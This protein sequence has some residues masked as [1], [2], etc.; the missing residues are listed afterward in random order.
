MDDLKQA[1]K[2]FVATSNSGKYSDFDTLLSKFPELSGFD[3]TALK[4]F[5]ATSNSG[6]YKSEDVL[7]SKF[8]EFGFGKK[9]E[10]SASPSAQE[11]TSSATQGM[12]SPE[13]LVYFQDLLMRGN[14][15]I[16]Q[17]KS[18]EYKKI[19]EE[20]EVLAQS[21]PESLG[22]EEAKSEY[23][24]LNDRYSNIFKV[25]EPLRLESF[26]PNAAEISKK[27]GSDVNYTP[28]ELKAKNFVN[29]VRLGTI[30]D[31]NERLQKDEEII[32]EE[33]AEEDLGSKALKLYDKLVKSPLY[34]QYS[35]TTFT[36]RGPTKKE[37]YIEKAA[38]QIA[39][40]W[41][42]PTPPTEED[43][44]NLGKE[45]RRKELNKYSEEKAIEEVV[46]NSDDENYFE[47][48]YNNYKSISDPASAVI[49]E[50]ES[51]NEKTVIKNALQSAELK[52]KEHIEDFSTKQELVERALNEFNSLREEYGEDITKYTKDQ[53]ISLEAAQNKAKD[54][55]DDLEQNYSKIE[56]DA[57]SIGSA[58]EELD[59]FKRNYGALSKFMGE[60]SAGATDLAAGFAGI[61]EMALDF[62]TISDTERDTILGKSANFLGEISE[63]IRG[64]VSTPK[65]ID[66]INSVGEFMEFAGSLFASQAPQLLMNAGTGLIGGR[67]LMPLSAAGN[68][69]MTTFKDEEEYK[70][71]QR[72]VSALGVGVA[73]FGSEYLTGR[74]LQR[75]F[76][77]IRIARA[78]ERGASKEELDFLKRQF[79]SG[80]EKGIRAATKFAKKTSVNFNEEGLSEVLA[81]AGGNFVDRHVLGKKDV[82]IL[83]GVS[84]AYLT[85]GILGSGLTAAPALFSGVVSAVTKDPNKIIVKNLKKIEKLISAH[86]NAS[87]NA[88]KRSINQ[89]IGQ[90]K[91][92]NNAIIV[93][94]LERLN[95]M[96]PKEIRRAV[97]INEAIGNIREEFS[98]ADKD[99]NLS[100][101]EKDEVKSFLAQRYNQLVTEKTQL[102]EKAD[103]VQEQTTSEV[104]VQSEAKPGEE[105]AEG[106]PKT[107]SEVA[108]EEGKEEDLTFEEATEEDLVSDEVID[109]KG[110]TVG[111]VVGVVKDDSGKVTA[112]QIENDKTGEVTINKI[113]EQITEQGTQAPIE[114]TKLRDNIKKAVAKV[115]TKT[116]S[117]SFKNGEEMAAYAKK[118]YGQDI[119]QD[120]GARV[121]IKKDGSVEILVNEEL[122]DDTSF[123]HEVW[124]PIL[125]KAFGDDQNNFRKFRKAINNTLRDNG[126]T[127]LADQ[128]DDFANQYNEKAEEVPSEEYMAQLGGILTAAKIDVNNLTEADKTLLQQIKDIVNNIMVELTGQPVF[129]E[130]AKPKDILNF[131]ST[132]SD[133]MA[134]GE[135]VSGFFKEAP[136]VNIENTSDVFTSRPQKMGNFEIKYFEDEAEFKKLVD[137]GLV[138]QNSELDNISGQ[139][140]AIHQPDNLLVGDVYYNDKK[141]MDANG[142]VYYVLKFGNVW[143]SGKKNSATS[144]ANLINKSRKESTDGKGRLVLVRGSQ[145]KMI[146]S[147]QGVK[148]AMEILESLMTDNLISKSDFRKALNIVGKK[149]KVNFSGSDSAQSIKNDI[150][151]KFMNVEDSTFAKRGDFF[152]DLVSEIGKLPSAKEN[153]KEIQKAL[154]ATKNISFSK[155]GIRQQ[156]GLVLTE[157]LLSN[158]PSSHVYAYIEVDEDVTVKK[159]DQHE[160]YPW[161]IRTKSGKK[162]TLHILKSRPKATEAIRREDGSEAS[163]AQLGLAQR[164]MGSGL[165]PK[166]VTRAQKAKDTLSKASGTTQ[167]ATTTGSYVKAAKKISDVKGDILDYG[168][169]LGL[170]TD[171]MSE[172]LGRTVESLEVNP[173]RWKGKKPVNYTDSEQIK[174]K[175]DGIVSLNVLNVVPRDVRDFIVEDIFDK[176]KVGGKAAISSRGFKG[177]IDGAK[178]FELGPEEKSYIIKRK[179]GGETIDV[180]QKGFD[181]NE[182]VDYIQELLGDSVD[183]VKDNTI[184]KSGVIITKINDKAKSTTRAQK[185][186]ASSERMQNELDGVIEK[187]RRRGADKERVYDDALAY[188]QVSKVYE[189][190]DDTA[191]E[192]M[193]RDLNKKLGVKEKR[194]AK[195]FATRRDTKKVTVNEK[196]ALKNLIRAEAK[197]ARDAI[198]ARKAVVTAVKAEL[199]TLFK[200]GLLTT[201]QMKAV[202]NKALSLNFFNADHVNKFVDYIERVYNNAEYADN[203]KKAES[204]KLK[205][206]RA[207]KNK[208]IQ[209]ETRD[210]AKN[211]LGI[212]PFFVEDLNEYL[213]VADNI[214]KATSATIGRVTEEG[215]AVSFKQA[216]SYDKVIEYTEKALETQ[217]KIKKQQLLD[218]NTE[219]VESGVLDPEMSLEEIKYIIKN[220]EENPDNLP[221]AEKQK[222]LR[223]F[224]KKYY[225][226]YKAVLNDILKNKVDPFTGEIVDISQEQE[227]LLRRFLDIDLETLSLKDAYKIIESID[228]FIVN[229]NTDGM[230]ASVKA[231]EGRKGGKEAK[232]K[233]FK[234]RKLRAFF[235]KGLGRVWAE[236]IEQLPLIT[237]RM[238]GE[239]KALLWDKLSGLNDLMAVKNK[240]F[241]RYNKYVENYSNQFKNIKDFNTLE[242]IFSRSILGYVSR[243]SQGSEIQQQN[244]FKKRKKNIKV[245][246]EAMKKGT[247]KKQKEAEVLMKVYDEIL[248]DSNSARE[249]ASKSKDFNRKAV[250]YWQAAFSDIFDDLQSVSRGVYNTVLERDFK[251]LP[252]VYSSRKKRD[253]QEGVEKIS[254][255]S[256][257]FGIN[258]NF[259]TKES[260]SVMIA[261]KPELQDNS[262]RIVSF[263]FDSNMA[264]SLQSAII[265]IETAPSIRKIDAFYNSPEIEDIIGEDDLAVL[266]ARVAG[267]IRATKRKD[268]QSYGELGKTA[269]TINYISTFAAARALGSL[270]QIPK[271]TISVAFNTMINSGGRLPLAEV[272]KSKEFIDN[273]GY[274]IGLRGIASQADIQTMNKILKRAEESKGMKALE[275]LKSLNEFY[276][277]TFAANPDVFIARVSWLAYYK[278]ELNRMGVDTNDIEW[279]THKLNRDAA[280]YAQRKTDRQQNYSDADLAGDFFRSKNPTVSLLR[281]TIFPFATFM[282]NK[283][284]VLLG[285]IST[286][287]NDMASKEDKRSAG[288]SMA[289]NAVEMAIFHSLSFFLGSTIYGFFAELLAGGDE[290]DEEKKEARELKGKMYRV[291]STVN[292]FLS[293][294]PGITDQYVDKGINKL[295]SL[296]GVEDKYQLP[297][298]KEESFASK[299]GMVNIPLQKLDM[300]YDISEVALNGYIKY[301]GKE[302]TLEKEDQKNMKIVATIYGLYAMG[303]LPADA[304]SIA[305]KSYYMILN[306]YK[307][308]KKKSKPAMSTKIGG[309]SGKIKSEVK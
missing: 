147:V 282:M 17:G 233:G 100:K 206:K 165:I 209:A 57:S 270:T 263:D 48:L 150:Q 77:G 91:E 86:A 156:I 104:P 224:V 102:I 168:A 137:D 254:N 119:G 10:E 135:D 276:L 178:N 177:D 93:G 219:L 196:T 98:N 113:D 55:Y 21:N 68:K 293:P 262:A 117:R 203:L 239:R 97:E 286:L 238:F 236:Q 8:P 140:V 136:G 127:E 213:E 301:R 217:E 79:S 103:A 273:S 305:Q 34:R 222:M 110:D 143:A 36:D 84:D 155:Q 208:D 96:S 27:A 267:Y 90:L 309:M 161:S 175:F 20:I 198:S 61:G 146:S 87:S 264:R 237:E 108:A 42:K 9:K 29:L 64:S 188:L 88:V 39:T 130:D 45:I 218:K 167:V 171:A 139:N 158:L 204:I 303:T 252:D 76:P 255:S 13:P 163:N 184:G 274:A 299:I 120:E 101:E 186:K 195:A 37:K 207:I 125:L 247:E 242:N 43:I 229:Q 59:L 154:G 294:V 180:Y 243:A 278:Q 202:L 226:T 124:H 105:V 22:T 249:V 272:L 15:A 211:F 235:S 265:D 123:G 304:G 145:D 50:M 295:L 62:T 114:G 302:I 290:E 256:A 32:E 245:S 296:L 80:L 151:E 164:G 46:A 169:G 142:G 1:L 33:F 279:E 181:G 269:K 128:L 107:E 141:I 227:N 89:E 94:G 173:E 251:Y 16:D 291:Q 44:L 53:L 166:V 234:A 74:V 187:A 285:D 95:K 231:Y 297:D 259:D 230:L 192:Q 257:F 82:G 153:I 288:L 31:L 289:S 214:F 71:W 215:P 138:V 144:L 268:F 126:Y 298:S 275:A 25:E 35:R 63:E 134:R 266:T 193:V 261:T 131:M 157:R 162:P 49:S 307:G 246:I 73:E 4:D 12:A 271:Q 190:A 179:K 149:Y 189:E 112:V 232:E 60:F 83:D 205:I 241:T 5:V 6:K 52:R 182:L 11:D 67:L 118:N 287:S 116:D 30:G 308:K 160:S 244:E 194:I 111:D 283:R 220:L 201:R 277:E 18:S 121:F 292:E 81:Q 185:N 51:T 109:L 129:L 248:A 58:E 172:T 66:R 258:E 40:Q 216:M 72:Y 75:A 174:K 54:L 92:E 250:S 41:N 65:E 106:T 28:E 183:V 170:G 240:A 78:A 133:M 253:R 152:S 115:F 281:K 70:D 7:L 3:A 132:M 26:V 199:D 191:R 280:D 212:E 56:N 85:G 221:S 148:A 225:D 122:A 223:D 260:G 38:Q 99:K 306:K 19:K 69:Y 284:S 14:K 200:R 47:K 300:A 23:K 159:D 210:I 197:A 2:D 176:L 228:N 24:K